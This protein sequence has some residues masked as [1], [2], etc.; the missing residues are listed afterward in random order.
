VQQVLERIDLQPLLQLPLGVGATP[1]D[2][3]AMD[4]V[5]DMGLWIELEELFSVRLESL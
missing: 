3:D 1:I 2:T 5:G 4:E